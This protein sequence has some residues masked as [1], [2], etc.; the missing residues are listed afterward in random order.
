VQIHSAAISS[1]KQWQLQKEVIVGIPTIILKFE[2]G[3]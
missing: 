3:K 1:W 2:Q